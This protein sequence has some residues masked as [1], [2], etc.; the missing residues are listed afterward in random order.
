MAKAI[1]KGALAA[2]RTLKLAFTA[3]VEA[4][5]VILSG[6]HVLVAANAYAADEAG[7]YVFRGPIEAPKQASLVVA[8]TAI[9]YWDDT[10]GCATTIATANTKMG[11]ARKAAVAADTTV[12]IEL[13][14]NK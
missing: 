14:E 11:I 13:A 2:M 8:S 5:D 3:A 10:A 1:L 9:L 6:G 7:I 4:G 12:L